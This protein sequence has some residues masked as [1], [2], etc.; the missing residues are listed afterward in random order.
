MKRSQQ[1]L[2]AVL[3]VQ[4]VLSAVMLWPQPAATV[5]ALPVFEGINTEDIVDLVITNNTGDSMTMHKSDTDGWVLVDVDDYPVDATRVEPIIEKL[6][7]LKLNRLVTRTSS[8]HRQLEVAADKFQRRISVTT[9][10]GDET[11]IYLGTAPRYS[12][13]HFRID[14]QDET[15]MTSEVSIWELNVTPTSW[16]NTSYLSIDK[17]EVS[18]IKVENAEGAFTLLNEEDTWTLAGLKSDE[19]VDQT[20]IDSLVNNATSI[21]L[22]QP[23]GKAQEAS[24]GLDDPLATVTLVTTDGMV[25]VEIGTQETEGSGYV[26]KSS[27]SDYYVQVAEFNVSAFVEN[28]RDDLLAQPEDAGSGT[29]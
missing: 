20:K 24:Y 3:V 22:L 21:T 9:A 26:V 6:L 29:E 15:Y 17:S 7:L 11:I 4:I 1:I 13:T 28:T 18:Q 19:T 5:D 12:A 23:L 10:S 25:T 8:S 14:G 16:V 27:E 2:A